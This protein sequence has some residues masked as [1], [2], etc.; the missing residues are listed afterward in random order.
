MESEKSTHSSDI[1]TQKHALVIGW[2]WPEPQSS[3]AGQHIVSI[4]RM[5]LS[6]G[7][8]VTFASSASQTEFSHNLAAEGVQTQAIKL[9]C[10]SFDRWLTDLQPDLVMFDRFLMEEQYGWRVAQACPSAL[11]LLDTED[12]QGLRQARK[13]AHQ[14]GHCL[15]A[16]DFTND[17]MKRELASIW[18]CDLSLIISDV[19]YRWLLDDVGVSP[20]LLHHVP[21]MLP[22]PCERE[23]RL[24]QRTYQERRD[25]VTIGNFQHAPNW[26]AVQYLRELWPR[27]RQRLPDAQLHIYGAHMPEKAKML[28]SEKLGIYLH[29]R[30]EC[31]LDVMSQARVQLAPL[32]FGA[33]LKGKLVDA[34][35]MNTPSVTTAIGIEGICDKEAWPGAVTSDSDEFIEAAVTLYQDETF[36]QDAARLCEPARAAFS[37]QVHQP[38]LMAKLDSLLFN[39]DAQRQSNFVGTVLSHHQFKSTEYFSRFLELKEKTARQG[40]AA[41]RITD[42]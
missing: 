41:V 40:E 30:A 29:G 11:K 42:Y 12:L 2:V 8:R 13:Q 33:G 26:D 39:V 21:F 23:Q 34:L 4:M 24:S 37:A 3:A 14:K 35:R 5:F 15:Q 7:W 9:N 20:H 38:S 10:S 36:W 19:E 32:R 27:I 6:Q 16:D 17:V 22:T 28:Q 1:A 18:R 25:F 31:A